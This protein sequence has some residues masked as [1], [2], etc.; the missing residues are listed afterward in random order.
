M[1]VTTSAAAVISFA[2]NLIMLAT[3]TFS[4]CTW[5]CSAASMASRAVCVSSS[6]TRCLMSTMRCD[7]CR[8]VLRVRNVT[9]LDVT[10]S[11]CASP[12]SCM[13]NAICDFTA[14]SESLACFISD[15]TMPSTSR[16]VFTTSLTG[17]ES[18]LAAL[19]IATGGMQQ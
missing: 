5:L 3:M 2:Q 6:D 12:M 19:D 7:W 18:E 16:P 4:V 10:S 1:S 17:P 9:R 8:L 15:S 14:S 13:A 11:G